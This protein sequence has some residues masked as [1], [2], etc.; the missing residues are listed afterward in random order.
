MAITFVICGLNLC[1]LQFKPDAN[2][3]QMPELWPRSRG[4]C[5]DPLSAVW[6]ESRA[7]DVHDYG[8]LAARP[9]D[10]N[11]RDSSC[12]R[13]HVRI[14][15]LHEF[16]VAR[17]ALRRVALPCNDIPRDQC[18]IHSECHRRGRRR[19]FLGGFSL[20]HRH[21]RGAKRV[22]ELM[23]LPPQASTKSR[24]VD[25]LGARGHSHFHILVPDAQRTEPRS[26]YRTGPHRGGIS[27]ASDLGTQSRA[28][29]CRSD[30][31]SH[32]SA[33]SRSC[34]A[35]AVSKTA[36]ECCQSCVQLTCNSYLCCRYK[37]SKDGP[38]GGVS[39]CIS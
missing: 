26:A 18:P 10:R 22:D 23:A 7:E 30:R 38:L 3:E 9:D 34:L 15:F 6:R 4:L 21:R 5:G 19:N 25:G 39:C 29:S 14:Y 12:P 13:F 24:A 27:T 33:E 8:N 2:F 36:I 16:V 31:S 17:G 28:S 20:R 35:S 37:N 11:L 1:V 32:G